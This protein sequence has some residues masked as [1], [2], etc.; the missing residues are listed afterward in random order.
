[1][2]AESAQRPLPAPLGGPGEQRHLGWTR[3]CGPFHLLG[4]ISRRTGASGHKLQTLL[5]HPA[6]EVKAGM[7][8]SRAELLAS[9][10]GR[11]VGKTQQSAEQRGGGEQALGRRGG[12]PGFTSDRSLGLAVHP[13]VPAL[14]RQRGESSKECPVAHGR[15]PSARRVGEARN[16]DLGETMSTRLTEPRSGQRAEKVCGEGRKCP[17]PRCVPVGV[18]ALSLLRV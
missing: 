1:M 8:Y 13:P 15:A 18:G 11:S 17:Q 4:F 14:F 12:K 5:P 16:P 2:S 3:P 9:G 7:E 6:C 10:T